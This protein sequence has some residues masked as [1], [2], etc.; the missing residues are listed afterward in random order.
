MRLHTDLKP[1]TEFTKVLNCVTFDNSLTAHEYQQWVRLLAIQ[2]GKE[3]VSFTTAQE[4]ADAIGIS[5]DTMRKRNQE[6]RRK[7]YLKGNRNELLVTIPGED[8]V[9]KEVSIAQEQAEKPKRKP[10]SLSSA[11][12]K[13]LIKEAWNKYKPDWCAPLSGNIAP[14]LYIAIEAQT[15]HL[16]HDRDDYDGFMK[17]ICAALSESPFWRDK[18]AKPVKPHGV[19]G[20]GT[21]DDKKFRNCQN[22]YLAANSGAAKAAMWDVNS[23][24][25]WLDWYASKGLSQFTKVERLKAEDRIQAYTHNIDNPPAPDTIRVYQREDGYP[26]F[27]TQDTDSRIVRR[28]LPTNL[29]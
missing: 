19:F 9:V 12:R 18:A 6:L 22:L 17:R 28:Q 7:G 14:P 26:E 16:D 13:T 10:T 2:H 29:S 11:D 20:W 27:W 15:K 1:T 25:D 4:V 3:H 5:L 21:P 8:F 24:Q 23:D